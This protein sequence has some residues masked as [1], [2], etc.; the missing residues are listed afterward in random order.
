MS[1]IF[2]PKNAWN[3]RYIGGVHQPKNWLVKRRLAIKRTDDGAVA[4]AVV[5]LN[6]IAPQDYDALMLFAQQFGTGS[7]VIFQNEKL[8]QMLVRE[9]NLPAGIT[10]LDLLD[11]VTETYKAVELRRTD[12]TEE[13]RARIFERPCVIEKRVNEIVRHNG[14]I[15][16]IFREMTY[17]K[18]PD[19]FVRP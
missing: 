14:E 1:A 4:I 18:A 8:L 16:R 7:F 12:Y 11:L 3:E 5:S 9:T 6:R 19:V 2:I 15:D 13:L 17:E 10:Q